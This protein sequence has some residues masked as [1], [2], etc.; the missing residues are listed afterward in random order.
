MDRLRSAFYAPLFALQI[1]DKKI[2]IT[3]G[4]GGHAA[5]YHNPV[6]VAIGILAAVLIVLLVVLAARSGGGTTTIL[7]D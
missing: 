2:E 3:V 4:D 5:W 6:W 1:P 7:K